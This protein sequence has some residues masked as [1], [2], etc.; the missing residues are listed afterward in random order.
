MMKYHLTIARMA[1]AKKTDDKRCWHEDPVEKLKPSY[2][3][4]D[5]VKW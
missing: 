1:K 2:F 5:V 3:A 4:G